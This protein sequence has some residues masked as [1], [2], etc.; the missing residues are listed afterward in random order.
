MVTQ[1]KAKKNKKKTGDFSLFPFCLDGV[2]SHFHLQVS[3]IVR[4][5]FLFR[6]DYWSHLLLTEM[7][8]RCLTNV[9]FGLASLATSFTDDC[10]CFENFNSDHTEWH[11]RYRRSVKCSSPTAT[12]DWDGLLWYFW[13]TNI[14]HCCLAQC[15]TSLPSDFGSQSASG[16]LTVNYCSLKTETCKP[17][18]SNYVQTAMNRTETSPLF[19]ASYYR[20]VREIKS[21]Q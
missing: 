14:A 3:C 18:C 9:R 15:L 1:H 4:C 10:R 5:S 17:Q 16:R 6:T 19:F 11:H 20:T 12:L 7:Y 13:L 21:Y 8:G 2:V